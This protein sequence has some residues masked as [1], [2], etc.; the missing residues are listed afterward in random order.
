M[1]RRR[2]AI[3]HPKLARDVF[4]REVHADAERFGGFGFR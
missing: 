2:A 4:I 3:H 1:S